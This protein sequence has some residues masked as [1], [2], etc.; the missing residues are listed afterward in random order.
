MEE[1]RRIR[2]RVRIATVAVLPEGLKV[3]VRP[4]STTT[5]PSFDVTVGAKPREHRFVGGWA[6]EGWPADV[7][8]LAAI[9]PDL[10]VVYAKN[11]SEGSRAWLTQHQL[12]WVDEAGRANVTLRSGLVVVREARAV[13]VRPTAQDRWTRTMLAA[14][15]AVLVGI[16]PTVEAVEV[17]TGMSRGGAANAL[18]RLEGHGLLA[19]PGKKRGA[20]VSRQ[21]V[22]M[23]NFVDEYTQAAAGFRSKQ[24]VVLL[25]RLFKDPLA[26]LASEVGPALRAVGVAWAVT[27]SAA[28]TLLAPYLGDVTVLELYVGHDLFAERSRLA[29]LLGGREVERG[30]RIEVREL[31]TSMSAK[32]PVVSGI[33]VALPARVYADLIAAGGRSAEAAHHLR[34]VRG[35]GPST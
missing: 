5:V 11:L 12:G 15:E 3:A 14:A 32:G 9:A 31:P 17:A 27:G 6:G 22:D 25:H 16:A 18:A 29:K 21:V 34:E 23:D 13:I 2:D 26:T 35:V 10:D 8:R 28:S 30:Q 4:R 24:K 33:Q 19:R 20:G 1:A 7:E